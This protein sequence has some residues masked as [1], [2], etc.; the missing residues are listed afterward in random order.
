[1]FSVVAELIHAVR[2]FRAHVDNVMTTDRQPV[3]T[4]DVLV[5]R[6]FHW[7]PCHDWK[8]RRCNSMPMHLLYCDS[9]AVYLAKI[10]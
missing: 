9:Y 7:F 1:M 3:V 5:A 10:T 4:F 6:Q 8:Q 2:T